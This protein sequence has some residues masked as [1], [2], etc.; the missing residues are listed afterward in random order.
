MKP[1]HFDRKPSLR[2]SLEVFRRASNDVKDR[3]SYAAFE[4]LP[5][6]K[7]AAGMPDFFE[8]QPSRRKSRDIRGRPSSDVRDRNSYAA[9]EASPD[10]GEAGGK[11]DRTSLR[12]PS[13]IH[14]ADNCDEDGHICRTGTAPYQLNTRVQ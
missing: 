3:N 6:S 1:D 14:K 11:P 9:F 2:S 10:G 8:R 7:E 4:T 5:N 12:R 13:A